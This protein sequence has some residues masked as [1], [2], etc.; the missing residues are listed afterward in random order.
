S[1]AIL[2]DFKGEAAGIGPALLWTPKIKGK[3]VNVI[4][5]W[6]HE[7]HAKRRLEGDHVFASIA[8]QF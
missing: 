7:F 6:L 3:E 8:L 5:K 2:G 1:G 4:V